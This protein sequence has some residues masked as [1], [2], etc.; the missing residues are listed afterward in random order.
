MQL[1]ISSH[2]LAYVIGSLN[3]DET[4]LLESQLANL[5]VNSS[6]CLT[7]L[8][9]LVLGV[10]FSLPDSMIFKMS[11]LSNQIVFSTELPEGKD[12]TAMVKAGV[13]AIGGRAGLKGLKAGA[14]GV[15]K[16]VGHCLRF[17][18]PDTP[19]LTLLLL[20][21]AIPTAILGTTGSHHRGD[22][23]LRL[24][25]SGTEESTNAYQVWKHSFFFRPE[26]DHSR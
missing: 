18:T 7:N 4:A 22:P 6:A 5:V 11:S 14:M 23:R 10:T 20:A 25:A 15:L 3:S 19:V 9:N 13:N 16:A 24:Q 17:N 26:A 1:A 21:S 12:A 2:A 8:T